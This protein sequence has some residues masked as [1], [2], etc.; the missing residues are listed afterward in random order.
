MAYLRDVVFRSP[1]LQ[2]QRLALGSA[3]DSWSPAYQVE[4]PRLLLPFSR[5]FE[6]RIGDHAFSCDP[7]SA[8]WLR[9]GEPY[10]L[11]QPWAGQRSMLL[12]V[13]AELGPSRRAP[14]PLS[15]HLQLA[16]W[17]QGLAQQRVEPLALEEGL[18]AL[19]QELLAPEAA[20]AVRPHRAVE[21]AREYIAAEPQRDDTLGEI[22]HAANCSA[23]HLARRFRQQTGQSLHG[24]RTGLR[25][26]MA[27]E[28]LRQGER[29]LAT[30]AAD[31]GYASHSHFGAVF[32]RHF[33][34]GPDRMR[35]N[36]V[37]PPPR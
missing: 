31:L 36:L 7:A 12:I 17:S 9:P 13:D 26:T 5:C 3:D 11:R 15:A 22:A 27:L 18:L 19:A 25:M 33:G 28:R 23:F 32:R 14:L 2:W 24:F 10:R 20:R 35:T 37:A 30:L 29:H 16:N 34:I 1:L 8:L 6:C 21:R 4:A